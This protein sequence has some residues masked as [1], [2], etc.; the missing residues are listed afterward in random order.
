MFFSKANILHLK[1][2]IDLKF[3]TDSKTTIKPW[4]FNMENQVLNLSLQHWYIIF[5]LTVIYR[6]YN[7]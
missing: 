1:L 5:D 7:F 3:Q 6:Y 2:E 4:Q